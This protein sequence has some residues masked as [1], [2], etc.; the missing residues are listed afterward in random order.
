[1]SNTMHQLNYSNDLFFKYT[2]SRDDE[3]SVYARNTIIESVT[4]I[5]VRKAPYSIPT[6]IRASSERSASFWMCM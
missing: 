5:R 4:R 6:W 2:L 1:M 3:G